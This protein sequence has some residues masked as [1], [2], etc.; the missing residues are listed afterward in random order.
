[1]PTGVIVLLVVAI[2]VYFGVLHR[3]LDRM[4]L[5]D[6]T[7]LFILFLMV[8]GSFFNLTILRSPELI[9][10]IGGAI[11]PIGIAVYL[12]ATADTGREK[13]RGTVAA[14]ISGAAIVLA[15]KL[16]NPEE[17]TMIIDPSYFFAL[18]AGVVGYLSGRSRRSAFIA[19]TMGVVL[20]DIAH[21]VEISIRGIPGRT[22]I[23][24]AG[25]FDAVVIA[26]IL[27]VGL[28][29]V[30]GETREYMARG[31]LK[32][33]PGPGTGDKREAGRREK[34]GESRDESRRGERGKRSEGRNDPERRSDSERRSDA[35]RRSGRDDS[36]TAA[37]GV[38]AG[39]GRSSRG[40]GSHRAG[41]SGRG[42]AGG[43]SRPR[44]TTSGGAGWEPPLLDPG[45]ASRSGGTGESGRM[46]LASESEMLATPP[47]ADSH[48][49]PATS[50]AP[51]T[52][53]NLERIEKVDGGV[54]ATRASAERFSSPEQGRSG[55]SKA[56]GGSA[57]KGRSGNGHGRQG[58]ETND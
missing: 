6:R 22:W 40:R 19:G 53:L 16:L 52:G 3:V 56:R 18:I 21:Y 27:A 2:L 11:V 44:P 31:P 33:A 20:A 24:G 36:Y 23:G 12:V 37:F 42:G 48:T 51:G 58:G 14:F 1:M 39:S 46:E 5:D 34:S 25:A 13:V 17:Q 4:R 29:E 50:V 10:N 28:A 54:S 49:E 41:R 8:L 9:V 47:R 38:T 55:G 15:M 45:P 43:D 32:N 7:A 26:G 57:R 35:E 30:V